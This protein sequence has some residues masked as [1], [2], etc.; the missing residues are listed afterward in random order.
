MQPVAYYLGKLLQKIQVPTLRDCDIDATA[1][2][3]QRS[4]LINVTMGRYSYMGAANS[5]NN[6]RIGNFCSI[7][8]YCAIGGGAH[9]LSFVSSSPVFL[10]GDNIF[11]KNFA[12]LAFEESRPVNIGNDVWIG[13]GCFINGGITIGD[14]AVIGAHSVVTKD[15]AP[16][17]VVAGAPAKLLRYRFTDEVIDGL[18]RSRW[19]DW[20]EEEL[21]EASALFGSPDRFLEF[22][23]AKEN[24]K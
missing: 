12:H 23:F 3:C 19:W 22:L 21:N 4:N 8:S 2:I 5:L 7:A 1:K 24:Q 13:E 20:S 16:F 15:V 17:A 6:V 11:G 9:P 10:D 14:G 18:R